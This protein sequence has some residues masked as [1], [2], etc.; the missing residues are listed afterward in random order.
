[1]S[2]L[3]LGAA[4]AEAPALM[5]PLRALLVALAAS[6]C[7]AVVF[8]AQIAGG[9]ALL[10][11]DRHD[12]AIALAIIEHWRHVL[13]GEA[14][15]D[16]TAY[17]WPVPDT[18]GYNDGYLLFGLVHAVF[19]AFGLDPF[20]AGELANMAIRAAGFLGAHLAARRV[21]GLPFGWALLAAA[22]FTLANN[23]AIRASHVQLF[24]VAF[25]PWLALFA[26]EAVR[27]LWRARRGALLSWG[28][29]ALAW[30]AA[31]LMTGFYMA[32]YAAFFGAALLL[33]WAA[34]A[35]PARRGRLLAAA[36]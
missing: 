15:W 36:R 33:A 29:A 6:A 28:A 30:H 14:A 20:L 17:F 1:M 2:G 11:G 19:R 12:G 7:T 23:L 3:R 25:L 24:S 5:L 16:R 22:L 13:L 4:G 27:A 10:F 32:W 31:M 26:G 8:R 18:L 21:L 9:F 35:G 34:V